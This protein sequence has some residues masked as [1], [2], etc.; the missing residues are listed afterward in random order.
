[1]NNE[2]I[3]PHFYAKFEPYDPELIDNLQGKLS[4]CYLGQNGDDVTVCSHLM[5]LDEDHRLKSNLAFGD[6]P[7]VRS[8]G[9]FRLY[10]ES[11][12][13]FL[14]NDIDLS[15]ARVLYIPA[16]G[17]VVQAPLDDFLNG[18]AEKTRKQS[19]FMQQPFYNEMMQ[20]CGVLGE[21]FPLVPFGVELEG[22]EH[23]GFY[24]DPASGEP[25]VVKGKP[26][27]LVRTPAGLVVTADPAI[28]AAN[29]H[30]NVQPSRKGGCDIPF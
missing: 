21:P 15:D 19:E 29:A 23:C 10:L 16:H 8:R 7:S 12:D 4:L 1:M 22:D 6:P 14:K 5:R 11:V 20:R 24:I 9:A 30:L 26:L 17:N 13:R 3:T 28:I 25:V 27:E 2:T 18:Y